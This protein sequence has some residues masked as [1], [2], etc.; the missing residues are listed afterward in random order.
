M[1]NEDI[2][3]RVITVDGNET[4]FQIAA[5]STSRLAIGTQKGDRFYIPKGL[6]YLTVKNGDRENRI[7]FVTAKL[8]AIGNTIMYAASE[9]Y[10]GTLARRDATK[11]LTYQNEV[12][13]A[14]SSGIK[15]FSALAEGKVLEITESTDI[16]VPMYDE[17]GDRPKD[18]EGN[19]MTTKGVAFD[20]KLVDVPKGFDVVKATEAIDSFFAAALKVETEP[21]A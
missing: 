6:L 18:T 7:R 13:K 20:C 2:V 5:E 4:S 17:N 19:Y 14:L 21:G 3:K 9:L 11:K 1:K 8:T 15:N 16:S 10:Q 12:V